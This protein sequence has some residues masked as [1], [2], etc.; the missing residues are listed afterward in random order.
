MWTF[1]RD[2]HLTALEIGT[3]KVVAI[4]AEL[5]DEEA[6]S[7]VGFGQAPS[8][9][10]IKGEMVDPRLTHEAI[11]QAIS[12]AEEKA[13]REVHQLYLAVTG[14]HLRSNDFSGSHAIASV[15]RSIAQE[16]VEDVMTQARRFHLSPGDHMIHVIRQQFLVDG[17]PVGRSPV[18]MHGSQLTVVLHAIQ[19][20]AEA[21]QKPLQC[22]RKMRLE[23]ENLAFSGLASGLAVLNTSQKAEGTLVI[24]LGG[25]TTEYVVCKDGVVCHSGLLAVG[26][27]HV[28]QDLST[29][30]QCSFARAEDL[31]IK[32]GSAMLTHEGQQTLRELSREMGYSDR[33]MDRATLQKIIHERLK[34]T[35]MIIASELGRHGMGDRVQSVVLCGGGAHM[36]EIEALAG[37][38]FGLPVSIGKGHNLHGPSSVIDRPEYATALGLLKFG[39][40]DIAR[41]REQEA[42]RLPLGHRIRNLFRMES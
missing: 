5:S 31:K 24:D 19:A 28:T 40:F 37:Y 36:P 1:K 38:V 22:L 25:G 13:D 6:L 18:G 4:I 30:L 16:D 34:E 9:G 21:L 2:E 32:H 39:A 11:R 3:C 27:D 26:G 17:Q 23:A 8:R 29:G 15:D 20:Q 14:Q 41:Q 10:V 33:R 35:F 7:V 42:H 12:Q